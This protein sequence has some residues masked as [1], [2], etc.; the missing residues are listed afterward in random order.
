MRT[1]AAAAAL[2]VLH[3]RHISTPS[4]DKHEGEPCARSHLAPTPCAVSALSAIPSIIIRAARARLELG[5]RRAAPSYNMSAG[6]QRTLRHD[7][8]HE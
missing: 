2:A 4:T 5:T 6:I 3:S 8:I 7:N 1:H